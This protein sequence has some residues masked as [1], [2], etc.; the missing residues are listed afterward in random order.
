MNKD[1]FLKSFPRARRKKERSE[2]HSEEC[3]SKNI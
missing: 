3:N 1:S 2:T